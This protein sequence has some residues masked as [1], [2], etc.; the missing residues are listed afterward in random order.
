MMPSLTGITLPMS[1]SIASV[2]ASMRSSFVITA[3]VLRPTK[4]KT[5][6]QGCFVL[7]RVAKTH[8]SRSSSNS[9]MKFNTANQQRLVQ[10][11]VVL[12]YLEPLINRSIRKYVAGTAPH[13]D[14]VKEKGLGT[15]QFEIIVITDYNKYFCMLHEVR[16]V[17]KHL[18]R[19]LSKAG[20]GL[21]SVSEL[22]IFLACMSDQT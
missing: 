5:H 10:E 11:H 14:L 7:M 17:T 4:G 12:V 3:R 15:V 8:H 9:C 1:T 20:R 18:W 13:T 22:S 6:L 16:S 2:P 19:R 21:A